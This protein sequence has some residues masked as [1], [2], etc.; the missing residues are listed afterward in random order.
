LPSAPPA[1]S[2]ASDISQSQKWCSMST[3]SA[4][5]LAEQIRFPSE[6]ADC[7]GTL[8]RP[9]FRADSC[10][11]PAVLMSH[12]FAGVRTM[13]NLPEVTELL[14]EAGFAVLTID[15]R[16]LGESGGE[17]RQTVSPYCQRQDLQNALSWLAARRGTDAARLGLWGTS[18]SGGQVLQTAAFDRRVK[19][20]VAQVPATDLFR[21]IQ[22]ADPSY[23][24]MLRSLVEIARDERYRGAESS[25]IKLAAP[26][27]ERSLFGADSLQWTMRNVR[28]HRS[29]LNAVTIASIEEVI[30]ADPADFIEAISPTPL[31]MIMANQDATVSPELTR[32]AF[33]R[34]RPPKKL[35]TFDGSHY[36]VYDN[37]SISQMAASAARDWFVEHL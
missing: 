29:F 18:F 1:R 31:L 33:E 4:V 35:M 36:D 11:L 26:D 17:P 34:A 23:R 24:S 15:F 14:V 32:A 30:Q 37:P 21:Q 13:K 2:V 27:A 28:E 10:A 19:A 9:S 3:K 20:V 25:L 12:G 16:F 7:A 22:A 8:F 5:A 6:N